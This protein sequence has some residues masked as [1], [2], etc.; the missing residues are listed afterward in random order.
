MVVFS[1]EFI[2]TIATVTMFVIYVAAYIWNMFRE[3]KCDSIVDVIWGL[4]A[5]IFGVVFFVFS[6][7][8]T[9]HLSLLFA[10]LLWG[11]RLFTVILDGKLKSGFKESAQYKDLKQN[12]SHNHIKRFFRIYMLQLIIGMILLAP[13][14]YFMF[15]V[16]SITQIEGVI[17]KVGIFVLGIGIFIENLADLQLQEFRKFKKS[18]TNRFCT[19]GLW[20]YSRHPNYF[21]ESLFWLGIAIA[22]SVAT[23]L[24]FISW[25]LITFLLVKVSGIPF[26]EKEFENDMA[27]QDYKSRTSAL[28]LLPPK[29]DE[30]K[31]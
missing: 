5:V 9:E 27:Y 7:G 11:F 10:L 29:E 19:D 25:A 17:F 14:M 23:P 26:S 1:F 28:I 20:K 22:T 16:D 31:F 18:E 30:N 12:W 6:D 24:S 2:F 15:S 21:G 13:V 3:E 8:L 4:N